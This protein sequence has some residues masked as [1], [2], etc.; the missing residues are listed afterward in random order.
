MMKLKF[1]CCFLR[2]STF[3]IRPA[4]CAFSGIWASRVSLMNVATT[5]SMQS[6]SQGRR[7]FCGLPAS[8]GSLLLAKLIGST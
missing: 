2:H 6:V 1:F 3:V 8:A 4:R 7:V 5:V